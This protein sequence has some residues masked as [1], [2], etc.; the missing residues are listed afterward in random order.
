MQHF[1]VKI[2]TIFFASGGK[3]ALTP[4]TKILRTFLLLAA[5]FVVYFCYAALLCIA[6]DA[7]CCCRSSVVYVSVCLLV[8]RVSCAK[9]AEPIEMSFGMWTCARGLRCAR[10]TVYEVEA[11]IFREN[12]AI[13]RVM[14]WRVQTWS[15]SS[16]AGHATID[17]GDTV[18]VC[19]DAVR[20][21]YFFSVRL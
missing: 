3:G 4:L 10:G 14:L 13:L 11:R 18:S 8:T 2:F 19:Y 1:V 6:Q 16:A 20:L 17:H 5:V 9:T 15:S 21:P 12:G 7:G